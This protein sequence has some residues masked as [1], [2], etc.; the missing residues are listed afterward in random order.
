MATEKLRKYELIYLVQPD[1]SDEERQKVADR[2]EVVFQEYGSTVLQREDWGKRKLAY[3]I[4]KQNKAYYTYIVFIAKPGTT[5]ELERVLRMLDDCVRWQ[6]IK[7]EDGIAPDD[8]ERHI[9]AIK[10]PR[11]VAPRRI[12]DLDDDDDDD[13]DDEEDDDA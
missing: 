3:E 4:R 13:D 7:L 8:I 5:A 12:L 10:Q 1:A 2:L 11:P 9:E 6:T